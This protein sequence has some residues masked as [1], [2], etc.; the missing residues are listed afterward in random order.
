MS[1][2]RTYSVKVI[3]RNRKSEW[4]VCKL[5]VP[6]QKFEKLEKLKWQVGESLKDAVENPVKTIGY[7][8]HGHGMRGK[9][10]W[11]TT[12]EDLVDMYEHFSSKNDAE[13][14]LWCYSPQE[15]NTTSGST[16]TVRGEKRRRSS[17]DLPATSKRTTKFELHQK[18]MS[19]LE[20]IYEEL[21]ETHL[22]C[23]TA[24]QL[25]AWAHL[26]QMNKHDSYEEP[27]NK[28]FFR[29]TRK[30]GS[31]SAIS[32]VSNASAAITPHVSPSK[33]VDLRMK[34]YQQLRYLQSLYDDGI[35]NDTELADQKSSIMLSLKN[36]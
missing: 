1:R 32:S 27:P 19:D 7:I 6:S 20:E 8:E 15:G 14:L 29:N 21:Q 17:E 35:I 2:S 16:S 9:Q 24:E 4:A 11:L 23:Y 33:A 5:R 28:P 26:I 18:K 34:N 31:S 3:N 13:I 10:R 25:R 30:R 12:D 22:D 36:L